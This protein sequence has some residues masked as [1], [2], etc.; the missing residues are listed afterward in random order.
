MKVPKIYQIVELDS[1]VKKIEKDKFPGPGTYDALENKKY[2]E[3]HNRQYTFRRYKPKN[4]TEE[5][6]AI[7]KNFPAVG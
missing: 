7:R 1:R 3:D 5:F 2:P 6:S 4:F